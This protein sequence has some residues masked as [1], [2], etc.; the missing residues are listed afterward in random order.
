MLLAS[1]E[2]TETCRVELERIQ[3]SASRLFVLVNDILDF[4]RLEAGKAQ[5]HWERIDPNAIVAGVVADASSAAQRAGVSLECREDPSVGKIPLDRGKV[6]KIVLNLVGNALKFTPRG[7]HID[8]QV[9]SVGGQVEISIAD[10]GP[11]IAP[12]LQPFLFQRFQQL[13]SSLARK[14]EGS[15]IGL[16]LVK[17]FTELM[18]G[19]V[20]VESEPGHGARFFVR[21]PAS[22]DRVIAP[23]DVPEASEEQN[24]SQHRLASKLRDERPPPRPAAPPADGRPRVLVVEDNSDMAAYVSRILAEDFSVGVAENGRVALE[25]ASAA[26]PDVIVSDVMMPEMDGFE[27]VGHLKR[28]VKLRSI[29]VLLLT[30]RSSGGELA[31]GLRIGA[32]DY[33]GKPFAPTELEARVRAAYRLHRTQSELEASLQTIREMHEQLTHAAK[34]AAVGTVIAGISHELNNPLNAIMMSVQLLSNELPEDAELPRKAMH[35]IERQAIRCAGLVRALLDFSRKGSAVRD[36]VA[37]TVL[38]DRV[39]ELAAPLFQQ[40]GVSF[41]AR[42]DVPA[43]V[44]IRVS[45]EELEI[46]LLNLISNAA[47]ASERGGRIGVRAAERTVEGQ[48]GI[49]FTVSDE[50]GGIAPEILPRIFEPF[51]TTKP[52]GEGTGLGLAFTRKIVDSHGGT[53]RVDSEVG[54]GTLV[55]VW[56]PIAGAS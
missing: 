44:E 45:I 2:L 37:P 22:A 46:A 43:G 56:L 53:I 52:P 31:E 33:L 15:G 13:D 34:L 10:T 14:H 30:A 36:L 42:S 18:G 49:V 20:G 23:S 50:G 19:T 5:V 48:R 27:L 7:G 12:E 16:A 29:P 6:E 28:D 21:F 38:L 54:R 26:P 41:S 39:T 11:G 9:H 17:E 47:M 3:R 25:L 4:T 8:V 32:D 1:N 40:R 24:R 35:M 55:D 51:F